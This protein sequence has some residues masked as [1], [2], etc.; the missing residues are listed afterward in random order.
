M[1]ARKETERREEPFH[2]PG[3]PRGWTVHP[4]DPGLPFL[5]AMQTVVVTFSSFL[6]FFQCDALRIA[7][8]QAGRG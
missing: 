7:I 3:P 8:G 6:S 4:V 1:E 5:V 2:D